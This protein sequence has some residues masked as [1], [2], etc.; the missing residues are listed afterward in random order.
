MPG[1]FVSEP[2]EPLGASFDAAAMAT[3]VPGVPLRFLWRGREWEVAAVE[4]T[5]KAFGDCAHGSGERYLRRHLYRVR[6]V[7]GWVLRLSCQRSFGRARFTRKG[8]WRIMAV[9][10]QP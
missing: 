5:G 2:I 4:E 9:E 8:R 10:R 1:F 7:D 6:T 3:G